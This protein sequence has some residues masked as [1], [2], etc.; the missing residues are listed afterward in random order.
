MQNTKT[1]ILIECEYKKRSVVADV[2]S[3]LLINVTKQINEY[4]ENVKKEL[5]LM[6]FNY[7]Y[8]KNAVEK[9]EIEA[10]KPFA[11]LA[12][13][14]LEKGTGAGSDFLGWIDLPRDYDKEEFERIKKASQKIRSDSEALVVIGIGGSY[15]GARAAIEFLLPTYY[16]PVSYTHLT[17]PTKA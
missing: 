5:N 17:L 2:F 4:I 15:L 9:H 16:N 7:K 14:I 10:L 12:K 8:T 13:D 3:Y 11:N 6:N 1:S